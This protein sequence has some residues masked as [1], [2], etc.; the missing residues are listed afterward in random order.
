MWDFPTVGICMESRAGS[1]VVDH[2][3]IPPLLIGRTSV[4]NGD[5][6]SDPGACHEALESHHLCKTHFISWGMIVMRAYLIESHF[7]LLLRDFFDPPALA[8]WEVAGLVTVN[9]AAASVFIFP[10]RFAS[11]FRRINSVAKADAA[12]LAPKT[13]EK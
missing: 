3:I 11:T 5:A 8:R 12:G 1:L 7:F 13:S 10:S 6:D 2:L 4:V 9:P